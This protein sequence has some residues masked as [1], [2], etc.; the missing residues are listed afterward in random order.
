MTKTIFHVPHDGNFFPSEL[1][2]SVCVS[3]ADFMFYH[4]TLSDKHV[5]MLIPDKYRA[6]AQVF[7][8]S[9]VLCDVERFTDGTEIMDKYGMGY[10]YEKAY[11]G[12]VIKKIS[13]KLLSDTLRYYTEHHQKF[14]DLYRANDS[15]IIVDLHSYAP[16][17]IVDESREYDRPFPDIC[18][19][20]DSA[21]CPQEAAE[22][23]SSS[24]RA[25]GYS[26]EL[27]YPNSGSFVPSA[28]LTDT[29]RKPCL[30]LMLEVHRDIYLNPDGQPKID[31]INALKQVISD[32]TDN[33]Q[34]FL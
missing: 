6:D 7:K 23:I 29:D 27:N 10:C 26:V 24:L 2:S 21:F 3:Y 13:D 34:R 15:L 22:Y 28:A 25:A 32:I 5:K 33:L 11:D 1:F 8:I 31:A 20:Y 18:V 17:L 16:F 14:N 19:G 4:N 12:R 30:S 9:R